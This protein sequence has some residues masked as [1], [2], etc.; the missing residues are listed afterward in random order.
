DIEEKIQ[1][2]IT[3]VDAE[4]LM[5]IVN[6]FPSESL[7]ILANSFKRMTENISIVHNMSDEEKEEFFKQFQND[8]KVDLEDDAFISE[9]SRGK[10]IVQ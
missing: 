2:Y 10:G 6:A 8:A 3:L 7:K 9:N 1:A 5:P 4:V